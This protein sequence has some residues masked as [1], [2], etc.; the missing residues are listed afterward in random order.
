MVVSLKQNQYI[1]YKYKK[2]EYLLK[3][4]YES[5]I[6]LKKQSTIDKYNEFMLQNGLI[7]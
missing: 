5:V 7:I 6:N 1:E 2:Q 3:V 4:D